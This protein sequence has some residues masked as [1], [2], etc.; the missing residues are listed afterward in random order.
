MICNCDTDLIQTPHENDRL[1]K[2][3]SE[4][5]LNQLADSLYLI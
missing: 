1:G 2:T 4:E 3:T 5:V